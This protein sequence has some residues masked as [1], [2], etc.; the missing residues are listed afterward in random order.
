MGVEVVGSG[1]G[2]SPSIEEAA[3][4]FDRMLGLVSDGE[5]VLD[6]EAVPLVGVGGLS[7]AGGSLRAW[8]FMWRVGG[9]RGSRWWRSGPGRWCWT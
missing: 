3:A 6:T 7:V 9:G 1:T 8:G 5:I 4:A 2:G